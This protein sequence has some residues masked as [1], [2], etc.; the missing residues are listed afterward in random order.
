MSSSI[1][2]NR[3]ISLSGSLFLSRTKRSTL[4]GTFTR[5]KALAP[6]PG[7]RTA[8]A[9]F[10]LSPLTNR[11]RMGG[12]DGQWRQYRKHLLGSRLTT[13]CVRRR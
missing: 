6:S 12:I 10:R 9:R 7:E 13:R 8:T 11:E 2:R 1:G 4:S 5:A 3:T